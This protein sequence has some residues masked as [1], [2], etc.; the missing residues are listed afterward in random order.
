MV[1]SIVTFD[2][3][4]DKPRQNLNNKRIF[5]G[6]KGNKFLDDTLDYL[7]YSYDLDK[8]KNIFVMGDGAKWIKN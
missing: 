8:V 6:F 2:G 7:Y 4:N 1:K 5:A 3:I